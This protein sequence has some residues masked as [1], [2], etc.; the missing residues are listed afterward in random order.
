[1]NQVSDVG[2]QLVLPRDIESFMEDCHQL[3]KRVSLV[4]TVYI[5]LYRNKYENEY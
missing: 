3:Q 2:R 1:M 5:H 4:A